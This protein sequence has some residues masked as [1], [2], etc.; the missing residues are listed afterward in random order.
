MCELLGLAF[1]SPVNPSLSFHG[2]RKKS[3]NNPHG[4]GLAF[5]P[6]KSC[7]I[8]KEPLK[9]RKS[10]LSE[11]I[12]NYPQI[13]SN[14]FMAHVRRSIR[15]GINHQNTHPFLREVN[16]TDYSFAHNGTLSNYKKYF[17]THDYKPVGDTDSEAVF[18]HLLNRIKDECVGFSDKNDFYW[19]LDEFRTINDFGKF[20]CLL[21]DGE[22]FFS[23]LDEDGHNRMF[24]LQKKTPYGPICI[25]DD[26][27]I[28]NLAEEKTPYQKGYVIATKQLTE[29]EWHKFK[30][31]ELMIIKN[32]E[33]IFRR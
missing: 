10:Y 7:Q 24:Y 30:P 2:F 11:F 4:W 21:S 6:D 1:N 5:Y 22:H 13:K 15:G 12:Q 14:I 27:F 16:G 25:K 8:I 3:K 17:L 19:L 18:C 26:D 20:N 9:A 23:Y 33:V 28:V 32:G 31:G 29:E